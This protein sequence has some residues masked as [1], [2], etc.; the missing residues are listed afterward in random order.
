MRDVVRKGSAARPPDDRR[1][2]R[3][4]GERAAIGDRPATRL[5]K[6][7]NLPTL[8]GQSV[9]GY[10]PDRRG[11]DGWH[12]DLVTCARATPPVGAD[13]RQSPTPART[14]QARRPG[15]SAERNNSL[16]M[17]VCVPY[18]ESTFPLRPLI[19]FHYRCQMTN[20]NPSRALQLTVQTQEMCGAFSPN[21][22]RLLTGG[23]GPAPKVQIWDV[24]TGSSLKVLYGH[25]E[26]VM[27]LTW[28]DDQL[29]V[30]SGA[31]DQCVRIWDVDSGQCIRVLDGHRSYIRSVEFSPSG[32][33]LLSGSG[34]GVV[35]L[36]DLLTGKLVQV[37]EGHSDGV[38][39]AVFD[40]S[41]TRILTGG[42]D[43][44]IRLWNVGTGR[45]LKVIEAHSYHVQCLAWHANQQ[46]FLSSANEIRFWD[47]ESGECLQVFHGHGP[48]IRTVAWSHNHQHIL[49]AS[50]D[51]TI[52]IWELT[53]G[54]RLNLLEGHEVCA[55]NAVWDIES[56]AVLSCDSSGGIRR[57][58]PNF[59]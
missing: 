2:G 4:K 54:Q 13:Y 34:D 26:P 47:A 11:V 9:G 10:R 41:Q 50:H 46:Q 32:E 28:T 6:A 18:N 43:G 59:I 52:Q 44:T 36:W 53:S 38:Y 7:E 16:T 29:R 49:S 1:T 23:D 57:W 5:R 45:C 56:R 31:S 33:L 17:D 51:C 25:R 27:S 19:S 12:S 35:R 42:R 30:A 37:F 8:Y 3:L 24:E 58:T 21:R 15:A 39:C 22:S 55:V 14:T 20:I 48:T 40:D